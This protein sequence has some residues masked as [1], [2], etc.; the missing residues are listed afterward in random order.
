MNL[1]LHFLQ[2]H[3]PT[4]TLLTCKLLQ[5][6]HL[7]FFLCSFS[8][9][10]SFSL[11]VL[12]Y[13]GPNL[14]MDPKPLTFAILSPHITKMG[15]PGLS[16]LLQSNLV[17]LHL[18]NAP[19]KYQLGQCSVANEVNSRDFFAKQKMSLMR[20]SLARSCLNRG[21]L[22]SCVLTTQTRKDEPSYPTAPTIYFGGLG[23]YLNL[24]F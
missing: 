9:L 4:A 8:I 20:A 19:F 7:C 1:A 2:N 11:T 15:L 22:V 5:Y 24:L 23:H 17:G 18:C 21:R 12:P 14:L 13:L 3:I 16:K 10:A 6:G